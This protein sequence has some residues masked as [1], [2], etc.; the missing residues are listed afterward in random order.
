VAFTFVE[1]SWE[2]RDGVVIAK[3]PTYR[4]LIVDGKIPEVEVPEAEFPAGTLVR[5]IGYTAADL[6]STF[7][8]NSLYGL[9]MRSLAKPLFPVWLEIFTL[10]PTHVEGF[11]VF[12]G[13]RRYGRVIRGT[14]NVLERAYTATLKR[15]SQVESLK[16][17]DGQG[18][19]DD[20]DSEGA[21]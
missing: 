12:G 8:E 19:E 17:S 13:Y 9:L 3:T 1:A 20:K 7:G 15:A 11:P 14:I 16:E 21:E 10:R 4:Y 6:L 18:A 2:A 5:H